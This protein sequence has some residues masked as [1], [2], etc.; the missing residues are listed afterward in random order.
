MIARNIFPPLLEFFTNNLL[1]ELLVK[2]TNKSK[3]I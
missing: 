3:I 2:N 1:F